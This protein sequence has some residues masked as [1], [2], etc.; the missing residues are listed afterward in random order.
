MDPVLC[1]IDS[2]FKNKGSCRF[3][4][5]NSTIIFRNNR[6]VARIYIL[7]IFR[8][9]QQSSVL[10]LNFG[11]GSNISWT[12]IFNFEKK[13]SMWGSN[14]EQYNHFHESI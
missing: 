2:T 1:T 10:Y 8:F 13:R 11:V 4:T 3:Q 9:I 5:L 6:A 14:P 12:I 7:Q